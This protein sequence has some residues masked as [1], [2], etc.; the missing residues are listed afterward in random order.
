MRPPGIPGL[1]ALRSD[2]LQVPNELW[3]GTVDRSGPE[4]FVLL[5]I[6]CFGV[7]LPWSAWL[8]G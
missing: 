7:V 5:L 3:A 8:S 1:D 6:N 4:G 2:L